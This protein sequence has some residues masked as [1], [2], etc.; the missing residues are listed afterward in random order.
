MEESRA[1]MGSTAEGA[2][3]PTAQ[4]LLI[5]LMLLSPPAGSREDGGFRSTELL[6]VSSCPGEAGAAPIPWMNVSTAVL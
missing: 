4:D 1:G 2:G 6:L 3:K 5:C